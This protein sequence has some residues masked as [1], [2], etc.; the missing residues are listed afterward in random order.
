MSS[1]PAKAL[2]LFLALLPLEVAGLECPLTVA[3]PL[4]VFFV[5]YYLHQ[6][7]GDLRHRFT[8]TSPTT[9]AVDQ[10]LELAADW[11]AVAL[12]WYSRPAGGQD[13]FNLL[14]R[15]GLL[16]DP[17]YEPPTPAVLEGLECPATVVGSWEVFLRAY[18]LHENPPG[19]RWIYT[20]PTITVTDTTLE[21]TNIEG[22]PVA[23][24]WWTRPHGGLT[25][26]DTEFTP[27]KTCGTVPDPVFPFI[28]SDG[29][30]GGNLGA[31]SSS[32]AA[33]E[34][35][36]EALGPPRRMELIP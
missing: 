26:D 6:D 25:K 5:S 14:K 12:E 4:E 21:L 16:P 18:Y 20:S 35:E 32:S 10:V 31:W 11:R 1:R 19:L 2:F 3:D 33:P 23:Y 22:I 15:C 8:L 24:V 28:F 17:I 36:F 30:E 34:V 9:E 29:F 27:A 13:G 7:P